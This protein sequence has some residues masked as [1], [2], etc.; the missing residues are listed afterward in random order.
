[1]IPNPVFGFIANSSQVTFAPRGTG[2]TRI[3]FA[4]RFEGYRGVNVMI[5]VARALLRVRDGIEV[6]FAGSGP[7]SEAV[8]ALAKELGDRVQVTKYDADE[9]VAF[10]RGFD[11][12]VVPSMSSEGTSLSVLEAMAAGCA[13]VST[14]VGGISNVVVDG[15]TGKFVAPGSRDDLLRVLI[16]LIDSPSEQR[17][18]AQNAFEMICQGPFSHQKWSARWQEIIRLVMR[19]GV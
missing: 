3:V 2:T 4:R 14:P 18:L 9:A 19:G 6:T 15:F 8:S 10:H 5:D 17:R 16:Q 7:Q 11:I 12:A 13:V 1:V